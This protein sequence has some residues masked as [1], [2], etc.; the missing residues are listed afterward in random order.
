M[1]NPKKVYFSHNKAKARAGL[2]IP[3]RKE[4]MIKYYAINES[5]AATAHNINSF[6][7]YKAGSATEGYKAA[8]NEVYAIVERIQ[9]LKPEYAER[10]LFMADRYARKY[11]EYLNDYYRNEASCPSVMICGPANFPVRKKERQNSRRDS[12]MKVYNGLQEYKHKIESLLTYD[13]P[14]MASDENAI[15]M[16]T[17]K[18]E[19][20]KA[21]QEEMKA[22]N[23]YY[24]KHGTMVGYGDLTEDQAKRYDEAIN[25]SWYKAP[26][27]PFSLSNNNANIHR[28]EERIKS[29]TAIKEA[30]TKEAA[31]TDSE[32]NELFQV[33]E[34]VNLMR[35][36]LIFEGKPS[37][38][39][40]D[41]L[42]HHGFKWSP[43]NQAWQRQLTDNAKYTLDRIKPQLI[44][45]L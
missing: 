34:N 43:A 23:A 31:E 44:E 35:L 41:I 32:G 30:G 19:A 33:V 8:V 5:T 7:S 11:A 21:A 27:A 36:Q 18:L 16:L 9:E 20:A 39:A 40:R 10:A 1:S 14:I 13:R 25:N 28:I 4:T 38:A 12:L 45:A 29:L 3:P 6:S 42:K 24:R 37:E 22:E 15:E 17:D 26:N 2:K